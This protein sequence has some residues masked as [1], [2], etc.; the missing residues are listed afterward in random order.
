MDISLLC[1]Y[2]IL[3]VPCVGGLPSRVLLLRLGT[4]YL[5]LR[6]CEGLGVRACLGFK[7][8]W[9]LLTTPPLLPGFV[10]PV[11]KPNPRTHGGLRKQAKSALD[12]HP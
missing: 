2:Y 5:G 4:A 1:S 3:G 7:C 6:G 12:F 8:S 11:R 9:V 10:S